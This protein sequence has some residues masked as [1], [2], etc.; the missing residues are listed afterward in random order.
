MVRRTLTHEGLLGEHID[1][2]AE[3]LIKEDHC[4]QS[5]ARC[6]RVVADFSSWLTCQHL[7]IEIVDEHTIERY[8][9]FR[10]HHRHPFLSDRPAL[11]RLLVLLR[12]NETIASPQAVL[13]PL[14]L[15]EQDFSRYLLRERGLSKVTVIR[16]FPPLRKFLR[17]Y[18][19]EGYS[20]CIKL[21]AADITHFIEIHA[22]DQSPRSAQSM[23]W[24]LRA[25]LRYLLYR[26]HMTV[27][28]SYAVPSV[29]RWKL[30]TLPEYL[31]PVQ[32]QQVL[33]GC[34]RNS[35]I[36]SR[37]HAVLVLLARLGLRA[38]EIVTLTLEDIDWYSCRLTVWGK[39]RKQAALPLLS[40][41]GQ[42]LANYLKNGRPRTDSRRVFI[43]S[44]AP[45]TGFASSAAISMIAASALTRAGV[46]VRRKGT[47]IFRHS[48]ATQLLQAGA[49]LTEIGQVLRHQDQDTTRIYAKVDINALRTLGLSWPGGVL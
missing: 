26:G 20:S 4:Y 42:A 49:S 14:E 1:L 43:R 33:D 24:T 47:H 38:N 2:Y 34:D 12:E 13:N 5:G 27:D 30:A 45:H 31:T 21:S 11:N 44:L 37:D 19:S 48:L 36:G 18:C 23:C 3:R 15:I 9:Q 8:L 17:E 10:I 28:L 46:E 22:H 39:G 29:R 41:V 25:F 16:H 7:G 35:P 6:I 40:V 32:V